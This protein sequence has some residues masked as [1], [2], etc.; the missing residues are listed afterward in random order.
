MAV[1]T[2]EM[3]TA[4]ANSGV[5][6][7]FEKFL[8]AEGILE[9]N[10]FG[11]LATGEDQVPK[12]IFEP[13]KAANVVLALKDKVAVKKLW[14]VCRKTIDAK[15]GKAQLEPD[16]PMDVDDAKALKVKWSKVH[17]FVVPEDWILV[18][19]QIGR[20]AKDC[21]ALPPCLE[22]LLAEVIRLR[23]SGEKGV[24]A[25][26]NMFPGRPAEMQTIAADAVTRPIE[27]YMRCRAWLVSVAYVCVGDQKF[28]DLQSALYVSDKILSAVTQTFNGHFAPVS[29]YVA[30]WASTIHHFSEE[31]R[32]TEKPL[33]EIVKN[34]GQWHHK[35]TNWTPPA[36]VNAGTD[37]NPD[38]PKSTQAEIDRLH[39]IIKKWQ[40]ERNQISNLY[41]D[42]KKQN[43]KGNFQKGDG[44]GKGGGGKKGDN[45]KGKRARDDGDRRNDQNDRRGGG[46]R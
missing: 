12:E 35:W 30:A 36:N 2:P 34:T 39:S 21:N 27:L 26:L 38:L 31:V 5:T 46:R 15:T 29:F 1:L 7:A 32:V 14:L 11:L 45:A 9:M 8:V 10:D 42:L 25:Q 20:L 44:K 4:V 24:G 19:S 6:E 17:N 3:K 37:A 40:T 28:F 33:S 18:P 16:A 22:I 41:E 13:A 23:S 43:N